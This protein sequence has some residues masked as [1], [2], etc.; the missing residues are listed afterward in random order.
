[1]RLRSIFW[2][3]AVSALVYVGVKREGGLSALPD[4]AAMF[5][6]MRKPPIRFFLRT[7]PP[8]P[9]ADHRSRLRF[10]PSTLMTNPPNTTMMMIPEW[11]C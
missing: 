3:A 1:M 6:N 11:K 4:P 2:I 8:H 9:P 10:T 7:M 5:S